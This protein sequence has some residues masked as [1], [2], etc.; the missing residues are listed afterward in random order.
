MHPSACKYKRLAY[1]NQSAQIPMRTARIDLQP[2]PCYPDFH[3][4]PSWVDMRDSLRMPRRPHPRRT[5]FFRM[6]ATSS[7]PQSSRNADRLGTIASTLCAIHCAVVALFPAVLG[8]VGLAFL[9]GHTAEWLFAL[10]AIAFA[11]GAIIVGWRRRLPAAAMALL[12]LGIVGLLL[13]RGIEMSAGHHDHHDHADDPSAAV[14]HV[15]DA[16]EHAA[17]AHAD[18]HDAAEAHAD[19]HDAAEAHADHHDAGIAALADPHILGSAIGVFAS[20]LLLAGHGLNLRASAQTQRIRS[21]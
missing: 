21:S 13:S 19:H 18:H 11:I 8:A 16:D 20:L 5:R 10:S 6:N 7:T 15:V 2:S 17:E 3:A 9:I 4:V 14:H 1:I 12:A